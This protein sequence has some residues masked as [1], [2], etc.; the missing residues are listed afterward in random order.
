M[1]SR[2]CRIETSG[3]VIC[4]VPLAATFSVGPLTLA[5][6]GP[7][8]RILL[9]A[10]VGATTL[11]APHPMPALI[12]AVDLAPIT[13]SADEKHHTTI[14]PAAKQLSQ[15]DFFGHHTPH[16]GVDNGPLSWHSDHLY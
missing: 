1:V 3:S 11:F 15:H 4:H 16:A 5:M 12:P 10:T 7:D 13:G 14:G 6:V 8:F 9:I 2:S